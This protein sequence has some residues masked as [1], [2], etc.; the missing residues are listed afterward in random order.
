MNRREFITLLGGAAA[1][2]P[3][4]ARAQQ[5]EQMRRVGV[6]IAASDDDPDM[7]SRLAGFR[8]SLERLG[9]ADGRN[10]RVD[11]VFAGGQPERFRP[12]ARELIARKPDVLF[13][14]TPPAVAAMQR[15]TREIPI[16]FADVSDPVGPGFI[17]SL[18]RPGGNLTGVISFEASITGKW[19][20]MLKEIAPG[21]VRVAFLGNPKTSSFDYYK[22]GAEATAPS[23][24]IELV[25]NQV[26]TAADIERAIDNLASRPFGGLALPPDST[27]VLHRDLIIAL[28]AKH[29]LPAV[30]AFRAFVPA[31]GLMSYTIDYVER[32]RQA[33]AYVD[34]ILRGANPAELPVEAP[35]KFETV[36]NLKTAKAMGLTVPAGLL[37]AADEVIE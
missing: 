17:A 27:T 13:V 1:A 12:L 4:G 21:L 7:R 10:L 19:L 26:E 8:Q 22:Q 35:T 14:Q 18:A 30:Y 37:V 28:A 2:W 32:Y 23:L 5:A 24:G 6:L 33:A 16:V 15:E 34:R 36:V 20:A 31:G 9:W 11:Y 25:P 29:R 3:C